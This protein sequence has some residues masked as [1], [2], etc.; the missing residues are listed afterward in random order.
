M[1]QTNKKFRQMESAWVES[2]GA[3][4]FIKKRYLGGGMYVT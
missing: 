4:S 2:A 1:E 3:L